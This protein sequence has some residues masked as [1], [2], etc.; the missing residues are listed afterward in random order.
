MKRFF[1]NLRFVLLCTFT[2]ASGNPV[3]ADEIDSLNIMYLYSYK[4]ADSLKQILYTHTLTDHQKMALYDEIAEMYSG[5]ELDSSV[6]YL[7]EA[8]Q[9]AQQLKE[10]DSMMKHYVALGILHSFQGHYDEAF[11][12]YDLAK[13]LAIEHGNKEVEANVLSSS[14]FAYAK[15][16]KHNTAIEY[17]LQYLKL[18]ENEGWTDNCVKAFA[19]L[20]EINRR[21]GNTE[22]AVHYL[23]QAEEKYSHPAY[24]RRTRQR[25]RRP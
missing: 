13:A 19:N 14:G 9:L 7:Q 1:S 3:F 5:T 2:L 17:Y 24:R 21:I 22:M 8:I 25:V 11:A 20:G 23:K 12:C 16:G 4:I 15:Q 6:V 18:S 10:Y